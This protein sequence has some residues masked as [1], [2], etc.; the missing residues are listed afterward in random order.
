[1][2]RGKH[3]TRGKEFRRRVF[4]LKRHPELQLFLTP[5][6]K[7]EKLINRV[8]F[9]LKSWGNRGVSSRGRVIHITCLT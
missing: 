4:E 3:V 6:H 5:E 9:S 8:K 7:P 2:S 1:M